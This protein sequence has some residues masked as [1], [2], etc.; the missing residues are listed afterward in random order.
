MTED[1]IANK[2]AIAAA[3][4]HE[5]RRLTAQRDAEIYATATADDDDLDALATYA[6]RLP[7]DIE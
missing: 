1:E 5:R 3:A 6:A 7:M 4:R 2:T